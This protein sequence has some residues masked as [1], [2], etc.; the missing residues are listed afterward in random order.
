MLGGK[1]DRHQLTQETWPP[2]HH[3]CGGSSHTHITHTTHTRAQINSLR[4]TK[5]VY[6]GNLSFQTTEPQIHQAFSKVRTACLLF[7]CRCRKRC[8]TINH[9]P[10]VPP[11]N[12]PLPQ[13]PILADTGWHH[14][15]RHHGPQPI[16]QGALRLLLCRVRNGCGGR[17]VGD[18]WQGGKVF[19]AISKPALTYK[20]HMCSI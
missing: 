5:V 17:V 16:H 19:A 15:A 10:R 7:A 14:Q 18:G 1:A 11:T 8:R 6:I 4:G 12:T 2:T 9:P 3:P 13:T 20:P